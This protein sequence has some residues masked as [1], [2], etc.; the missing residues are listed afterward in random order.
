MLKSPLVS[1]F[2]LELCLQSVIFSLLAILSLGFITAI[3]EATFLIQAAA[4]APRLGVA[5][6]WHS[7]QLSA[8]QNY[9]LKLV[10]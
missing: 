2:W 3:L 7:L 9:F 8:R 1:Y 4:T 6:P 10:S 5:D